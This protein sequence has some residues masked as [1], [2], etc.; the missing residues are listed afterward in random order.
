MSKSETIENMLSML[1]EVIKL[2]VNCSFVQ[3]VIIHFKFTT[4]IIYLFTCTL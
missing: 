3:N 4:I 1:N 2:I